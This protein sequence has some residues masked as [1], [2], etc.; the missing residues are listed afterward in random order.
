MRQTNPM[1][2]GKTTEKTIVKLK[3]RNERIIIKLTRKK[4]ILYVWG[5][6]IFTFLLI[7]ILDIAVCTARCRDGIICKRVS[8]ITCS[9]R[10]LYENGKNKPAYSF[11][12]IRNGDI[13]ITDSVHTFGWRHGHAA[14]VIDADNKKMLEAVTIGVPVSI[15]GI[16]HWESYSNVIHARIREDA[17]EAAIT[18]INP[19]RLSGNSASEKLGNAAAEYAKENI[20]E[21]R[22]SLASFGG[23]RAEPAHEMTK[24]Q[25]A[26]L[27]WCIYKHFGI[28]LDSTGGIIV[29]PKDI[30]NSE[31]L[32]IVEIF[33]TP[34]F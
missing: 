31:K 8:V 27:V 5:V 30:Y 10:Y 19:D 18:E 34:A 12:N 3:R 17:A 21:L 25:C 32:E 29:T 16:K 14:I 2:I 6:L 13:F 24:T 20:K 1:V 28:D 26:H 9:D 4:R 7:A 15:R 22:Y 11:E 23:N 33:G